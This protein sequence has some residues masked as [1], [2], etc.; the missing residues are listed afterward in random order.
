[1]WREVL[2]ALTGKRI[3]LV[4][5]GNLMRQDDAIGVVVATELKR[6]LMINLFLCGRRDPRGLSTFGVDAKPEAVV[7]VDACDCGLAPGEIILLDGADCQCG[8]TPPTRSRL[9]S[10]VE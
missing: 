1:M 4:G 7:L 3:L 8:L 10:S 6:L 2:Q 5:I 9:R